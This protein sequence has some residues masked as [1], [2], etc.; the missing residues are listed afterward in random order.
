[1]DSDEPF[2]IR[3]V[4]APTSWFTVNWPRLQ[5]EVQAD[6]LIVARCRA[7]PKTCS[8]AALQFVAIVDE[9]RQQEGLARI[10]HINRAV[11]LAIHTAHRQGPLVWNSPLAVLTEGKSDCSGFAIVKYAALDD[12]GVSE[13]R[14]II[15]HVESLGEDHIVASVRDGVRWIILDNRTMVLVDSREEPGFVPLLEFEQDGVRQFASASPNVAGMPC[16]SVVT[17]AEQDR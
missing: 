12:V 16:T 9:A 15:V 7:E 3:T 17:V 14:L 13:H 2:G 11:N 1:M 4:I 8:P 6:E 10:G 5:S